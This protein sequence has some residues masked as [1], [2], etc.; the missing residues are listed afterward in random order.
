MA[1]LDESYLLSNKTAESLYAGV[2]DLPIVDPHNHADV[3]A[4]CEN[5]NFTDLWEAEAATDHYV[6]EV[7]RKR[8]VP[9]EYITGADISNEEKWYSLANVFDE[10]VGNPTFEWVHLDLR[11]C[12]GIDDLICAANARKVWD[13]ANARLQAPEM[14]PQSL[15]GAMKVENMCSTDDPADSLEYH[16]RLQKSAV[17]GMVRPTFRPDA[18][19]NVFRNDWR[20][21]ISRLEDCAGVK[22][23]RLKDLIAALQARH[24]YFAENGCVASDHGVETPYGF[25]VDPEDADAIFRKAYQGKELTSAETVGYMSYILN[26]M[27]EMNAA[28]GWVF[29]LH[30][31]AVRD[32]RGTLYDSL[33][34]DSGGD[35]SNHL[36]DILTPL[37]GL[38]NRFDGRLKV[39]FYALDPGHQPT[40]ATLCR[41]FGEKVNLGVTW[42]FNDSPVGMKRQLE[43][44]SSV[45][46]LVN[47]AGMVSD[48]RK[49]MS[50]G[51]RNEMFRRVL[52]D[53]VGSMVE[54]GQAPPNLAEKLVKHLSYSRP[55]E[56]F[57]F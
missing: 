10:L 46:L 35:V 26:E 53:V 5:R 11:R 6:W 54:L 44:V 22:F 14:R 51:S 16:Q 50:Y 42:W 40:L 56:L 17:A 34:P 28:K 8:G 21:Y 7:L 41:A 12:L 24:D 38:L 47:L 39:V 52:C 43:Y 36:T 27:A 18:V 32:V 1:F 19:M 49:L 57:S 20:D 9:E 33:G 29:Q 13:Q 48:S 2:A 37:R 4:I 30:I 31:G 45:D 55:K 23:K 3:R 15:L 25:K